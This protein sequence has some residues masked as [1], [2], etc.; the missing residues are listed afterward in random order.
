MLVSKL[1]SP[2]TLCYL[3]DLMVHTVT[4]EQHLEELRKVFMMHREAGIR[5]GLGVQDNPEGYLHAGG[6]C[7]E[8]RRVANTP[9]C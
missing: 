3:D 6:L 7:G 8:D 9:N 5:L 4:T 2:W 1:R